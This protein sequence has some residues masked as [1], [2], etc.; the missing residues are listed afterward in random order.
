LD[1]QALAYRNRRMTS[2]FHAVPYE[3]RVRRVLL[4]LARVPLPALRLNKPD[5]D[6]ADL[7]DHLGDVL[8]TTPAIRALRAS[9]LA[10]KL[11]WSLVCRC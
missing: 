8:L 1:K 10:R 2:A 9:T 7:P 3:H 11:R 5:R 4:R 6:P